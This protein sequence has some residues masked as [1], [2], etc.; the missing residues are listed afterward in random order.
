MRSNAAMCPPRTLRLSASQRGLLSPLCA[1]I[2]TKVTANK[3]RRAQ[4]W[5]AGMLKHASQ[6]EKKRQA[7][8]EK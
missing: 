4:R 7:T 3:L 5:K 2:N 8:R 6:K 1:D